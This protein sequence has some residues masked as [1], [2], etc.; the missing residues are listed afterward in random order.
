MA[1]SQSGG[2]LRKHAN[3]VELEKCQCLQ[4]HLIMTDVLQKRC[5]HHPMD[6]PADNSPDKHSSDDSPVKGP[7]QHYRGIS[8]QRG[9]TNRFLSDLNPET[10]LLE[11][12]SADG[13][14]DRAKSMTSVGVWVNRD[15]YETLVK[16]Q[17]AAFEAGLMDPGSKAEVAISLSNAQIEGLID[18]YF[19]KIHPILP[20]LDEDDFRKAYAGGHIP[21]PYTYVV[22][23]IA[24]KDSEASELLQA[25]D[26]SV[27]AL[28]K[29]LHSAVR[30][31]IQRNMRCD[32]ITLIR[33][34]AL[35][36]MHNEGSDGAD[37]ASLYLVQAMHHCQTLGLHLSASFPAKDG[38]QTKRLFWCLW[39]LDRMTAAMNGRPIIMADNDVAIE[40]FQP[41]ESGFPALEILF[42][43][44][45]VLNEVIALYRPGNAPT[46][47]GWEHAFPGFEEI[48]DMVQGW[49]LPPTVLSTL[50]IAYLAIA[51]LSHRSKGA[52][53]FASSTPSYVRQSMAA[54]QIVRLMA[55]ARLPSLHAIPLLPYAISL[56]LSVSY[57]HM[58]QDQLL[59]QQQDAK[60]DFEACFA[61]LREMKWTW[62][63]A[64]AIFTLSEKVI[65]ELG[66]VS[67][68]E[69]FR[70]RRPVGDDKKLESVTSACRHHGEAIGFSETINNAESV[71]STDHIFMASGIQPSSTAAVDKAALV[72]AN[73]LFEGI[74]DIFGT[75]MDPNYPVNLDFLDE[76]GN[77]DTS[78]WIPGN[79]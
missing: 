12:T 17:C 77:F 6:E 20:I 45:T 79:V 66:K 41:G 10:R 33:M 23:L 60:G 44:A 42:K 51:I 46:T 59:Y 69:S 73:G 65:G 29:K 35:L 68:I 61:I 38:K 28:C 74:D 43:I 48:V 2:D 31:A 58:R 32:K 78:E 1:S 37:E 34:L 75:F 70:I 7:Q 54:I 47:T 67:G 8:V 76:S 55:P 50:H 49:H 36:S 14:S 27:R 16:Q 4:F 39:I 63:S 19:R 11:R 9:K 53:D 22:C 13:E 40:H 72:S 57:Q 62:S 24:A 5:H 15:E 71:Q 30:A 52:A 64:D 26:V 21:Q 25:L 3:R 18:V 56:A